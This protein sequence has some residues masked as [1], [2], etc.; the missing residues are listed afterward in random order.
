MFKNSIKSLSH[1]LSQCK[2][3]LTFELDNLFG[4][5]FGVNIKCE[6][7]TSLYLKTMK[8]CISV[9]FANTCNQNSRKGVAPKMFWNIKLSDSNVDISRNSSLHSKLFLGKIVCK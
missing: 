9:L 2:P 6:F 8:I 3:T 4:E 5:F 7:L 1:R